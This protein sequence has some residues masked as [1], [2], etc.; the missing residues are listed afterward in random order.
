MQTILDKLKADFEYYTGAKYRGLIKAIGAGF[1]SRLS[2][3]QGKLSWIERQAFVSTADK[4][5]L[6]LHAGELLPPKPAETATGYVIFLGNA[7][8]EIPI[9]TEI[10]DDNSEYTTQSA[11]EIEAYEF[12]ETASVVDGQAILPP[13]PEV[14]SCECVANGEAK[15]AIS[16]SDAF[17]FE[18]GTIQNGDS[19]TVKL[20][21]SPLVAVISNTSGELGNKE[22]GEELKTKVT[23]DSI[24]QEVFVYSISGGADEE[25]VEEY[26]ARVKYFLANPQAPFSANHIRAELINGI[27]TLKY[28]WVKGGEEE[29]G[30]VKI[31]VLNKDSNLSAE[32]EEQAI[33][34]V[35]S[36]RPPQMNP[37]NLTTSA[38]I[39]KT[40][41]IKIAEIYPSHDQMTDAVS[42]NLHTLFDDDLFE[43]GVSEDAINSV[44]Y[45]TEVN[46]ERVQS[47]RLVSGACEAED[48]TQWILGTVSFE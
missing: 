10:K 7:G 45:R 14:P 22:F 44:I 27:S 46:G 34:I 23:I 25:D 4:E 2:E 8:A 38:P 9:G 16:S 20:S 17:T 28:V 24:N 30:H 12:T 32:E 11:S 43:R 5:Y 31:F 6:Y 37:A 13:Q 15:T 42:K 35:Q 36:L 47:F 39:L 29:D 40:T 26:R 21:K 48:Y 33:E 41:S 18:A 3:F 19:V 1:A